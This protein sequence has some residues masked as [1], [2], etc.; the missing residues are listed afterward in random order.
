MYPFGSFASSL[1]AHDWM[2]GQLASKSAKQSYTK[3]RSAGNNVVTLTLENKGFTGD[4]VQSRPIEMRATILY[5]ANRWTKF[6][7][8]L[9]SSRF[10]DMIRFLL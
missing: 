8:L 1:T 6:E 10:L 5:L 9:T 4:Y 7:M 3:I 2:I